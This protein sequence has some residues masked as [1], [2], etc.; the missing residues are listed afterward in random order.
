MGGGYLF[1]NI[2][3]PGLGLIAI[4]VGDANGSN[5][6]YV[7]CA[8]GDQMVAN[9]NEYRV[10][11]YVLP[12]A[13]TDGWKSASGFDIAPAGAYVAKFYSDTKEP[14][15][16]QIANE[17]SP[18]AGVQLF[19]DGAAP[20]GVRYFDT[21]ARLDQRQRHGH[22]QRRRGHRRGAGLGQ[23]PHLQRQRA[24]RACRSPG[25]PIR[26]ARRRAWCS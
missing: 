25:R 9:G 15:T 17:K 26:A 6:T 23:L 8:T 20:A 13:V 7:N 19:E 4:V 1:P 11:A 3:A 5:T 21:L 24:R 22:Q 2:P 14:P 10:D 16:S 12:R 18:V